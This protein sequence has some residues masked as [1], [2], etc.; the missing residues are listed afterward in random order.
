MAKV[1]TRFFDDLDALKSV[2]TQLVRD[3][4]LPRHIVRAYDDA[5]GLVVALTTKG[6]MPATAQ[7]YQDRMA[8][9]GAVLMVLADYT[10]LGVARITRETLAA[11]DAADLGDLTEEVELPFQPGAQRSVLSGSPLML[12]RRL[13]QDRRRTNFFMADRPI[14]HLTEKL[15]G[16]E[17]LIS[18]HGR[19]ASWPIG[20]LLPG[21]VRYGRFPFDLLVPGHKFMAKFP[22]GHIVPGHKYMAKFPFGHIVPGHKFMAKFPFGHIVP[23]HKFQAKFPFGH[24][25]PGHRRMAN[26]PFPLLMNGKR[27]SV[28]IPG[29]SSK[30]W[31]KKPIDHL[32]PRHKFYAKFPFAHLIPGH[33]FMAKFPFG[34]IVP[35]HKYM[36]KFP[37]AHIV[38]GHKHMAKFPFGHIVPGHKYMANWIFPHTETKGA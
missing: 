26:W 4:K 5:D 32:T 38:P 35:G 9:G 13:D 11:S 28:P 19:M 15:P 31:A 36:A 6:V 3:K 22:F 25:V 37:F 10:P 16:P 27:P 33:K 21:S 2:S 7:A 30:F 14:P 24:L 23:G 1:I 34:H 17:P 12:S 29:G 20:L 8:K 18:P